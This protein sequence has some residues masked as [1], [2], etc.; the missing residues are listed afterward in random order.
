MFDPELEGERN[1]QSRI[2][3]IAF[4]TI[5]ALFLCVN[6]GIVCIA[7]MSHVM[8][9]KRDAVHVRRM[10]CNDLLEEGRIFEAR[11][12]MTKDTKNSPENDK[13][14][15]IIKNEYAD[16]KHCQSRISKN[17]SW[18]SQKRNKNTFDT[19]D[20]VEILRS[21]NE[22]FPNDYC[23]KLDIADVV[24]LP[25]EILRHLNMCSLWIGCVTESEN[26]FNISKNIYILKLNLIH[27][28][29]NTV[30]ILAS[31]P[32]FVKVTVFNN[33]NV[34]NTTGIMI[35]HLSAADCVKMM[36]TAIYAKHRSAINKVKKHTKCNTMGSFETVTCFFE[37]IEERKHSIRENTATLEKLEV[38]KCTIFFQNLTV[39]NYMPNFIAL[40]LISDFLYSSCIWWTLHAKKLS[41]STCKLS[42]IRDVIH[43]KIREDE[44]N[45]KRIQK[46]LLDEQE[47]KS[48][49]EY[50]LKN[51][52]VCLFEI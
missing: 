10:S 41:I 2:Q 24:D 46:E 11:E 4:F 45:E 32:M 25:F 42:Q 31:R 51:V 17:T 49:E 29:L 7:T 8:L 50:D 37:G 38:L 1:R 21:K 5:I 23:I 35:K 18:K 22:L 20:N 16:L 15:E 19:D 52:S 12:L 40:P 28:F 33:T 44:D 47:R 13:L 26:I 36:P 27:H 48:K 30:G 14:Y 9:Y 34:D 39:S 3:N 6:Y 43:A